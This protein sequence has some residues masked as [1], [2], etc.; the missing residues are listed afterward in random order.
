MGGK[1]EEYC[2]GK[3]ET[4]PDNENDSPFPEGSHIGS[5]RDFWRASSGISN[6]NDR[7]LQ[8]THE[9]GHGGHRFVRF[10]RLEE[11][12]RLESYIA[13]TG[14]L[15]GWVE[16]SASVEAT[17]S[18]L[19]LS[20]SQAFFEQYSTQYPQSDISSSS[21]ADISAHDYLNIFKGTHAQA[22]ADMKPRITQF[23]IPVQNQLEAGSYLLPH[24]AHD[25]SNNFSTSSNIGRAT[26]SLCTMHQDMETLR[27]VPKSNDLLIAI[28]A[29]AAAA[30]NQERGSGSETGQHDRDDDEKNKATDRAS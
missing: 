24:M 25:D 16:K 13:S 5:L 22:K 19:Q 27:Q 12:P 6:Q 15:A 17:R 3:L 23:M 8:D 1:E 21:Q 2:L 14:E 18:S 7:L 26:Q 29:S 10:S 4:M 20:Q 11:N 9:P 30:V 28:T